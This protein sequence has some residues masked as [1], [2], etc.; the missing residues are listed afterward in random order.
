MVLKNKTTKNKTV[1]KTT[2][3]PEGK[4]RKGCFAS[5]RALEVSQRQGLNR[6]NKRDGATLRS[7]HGYYGRHRDRSRERTAPFASFLEKDWP[8]KAAMPL[9]SSG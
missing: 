7:A 1:D 2:H 6:R 3:S 4:E 8:E 9:E 5:L